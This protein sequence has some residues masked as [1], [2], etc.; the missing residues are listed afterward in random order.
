MEVD[1]IS[2]FINSEKLSYIYMPTEIVAN[3]VLAFIIGI[4]I[5]YIYKKHI[6]D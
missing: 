3:L 2:N 4:A 5:S 1:E 6:K